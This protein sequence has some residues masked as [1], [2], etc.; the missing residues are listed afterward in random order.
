MAQL[1]LYLDVEIFQP[2]KLEEEIEENTE[3]S[4]PEDYLAEWRDIVYL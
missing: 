4:E 2:E 1:Y 3:P